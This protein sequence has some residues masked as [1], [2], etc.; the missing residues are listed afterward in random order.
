MSLSLTHIFRIAACTCRLCGQ[1]APCIEAVVQHDSAADRTAPVCFDCLREKAP[2]EET[3]LLEPPTY[4]SGARPPTAIMKRTA[5]RR[6]KKLAR[7]IGGR[8]QPGSG[9]GPVNKG[10]VRKIGQWLGDDKTCRTADKGYRLTRELI[11]KGRSWCK[12]GEK[13]FITIGFLNK[14][15]RQVEEEVVVIDRN[16]FLEKIADAGIDL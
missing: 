8:K 11:A 13:F 6:E 2:V 16:V 10:D 9:A 3:L 1:P 14:I 5:D 15:T 12:K 7:Q 4:G